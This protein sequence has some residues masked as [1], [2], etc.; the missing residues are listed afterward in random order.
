[1]N[2]TPLSSTA[3]DLPRPNGEHQR[4]VHQP[5]PWPGDGQAAGLMNN[6]VQGAHDTIDR[7]AE[8][9]AS[10]VRRLSD[11]AA[12]AGRSLQATSDHLRDT[13]DEWMGGM[14]STVR[15]HPLLCIAA[16]V[17]LGALAARVMRVTR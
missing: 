9:T 5:A 1:M 6:A 8:G 17:A 12:A 14:R 16:A 4:P 2:D 13:R 15:E 3:A 7:V 11:S 10:T